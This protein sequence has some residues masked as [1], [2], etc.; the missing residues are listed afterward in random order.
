MLDHDSYKPATTDDTVEALVAS[1]R[2]ELLE[3]CEHQMSIY[4]SRDDYREFL[5]LSVIFMDG[6]PTRGIHFQAP[7]AM[8]RARWMAKVMYAIKIWLFRDQFRLTASEE[9]G[10]RDLAILQSSFISRPG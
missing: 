2:A 7:G 8:H 1:S 9:K 3:F 10:I 5:K 4:H 6:V